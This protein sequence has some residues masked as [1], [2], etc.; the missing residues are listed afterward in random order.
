MRPLNFVVTSL[1]FVFVSDQVAK[2]TGTLTAWVCRMPKRAELDVGPTASW[3]LSDLR[4]R[5]FGMLAVLWLL[6]LVYPSD[7]RPARSRPCPF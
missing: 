6:N 5:C 3:L 7:V 1:V 4:V 2:A